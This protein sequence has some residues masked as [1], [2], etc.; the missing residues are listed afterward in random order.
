MTKLDEHARWIRARE[1]LARGDEREAERKLALKV[2]RIGY[3]E[4]TKLGVS[5]ER[6]RSLKRI[7]QRLR[8]WA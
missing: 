1:M 6:A 8:M 2:I 3:K 5:D 7:T 4:L